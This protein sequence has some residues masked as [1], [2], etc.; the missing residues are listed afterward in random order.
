MSRWKKQIG[1]PV[2]T[3]WITA[4]HLPALLIAVM[5][6]R[7]PI[8]EDNC[9]ARGFDQMTQMAGIVGLCGVAISFIVCVA[10]VLALARR[11]VTEESR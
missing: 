1:Q 2:L 5:A 11:P 10:G 7:T 9:I 6:A 4:A 3:A 8:T